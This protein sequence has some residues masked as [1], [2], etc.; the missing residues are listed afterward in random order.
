MRVTLDS[1]TDKLMALK[2]KIYIYIYKYLKTFKIIIFK[3]LNIII[4]TK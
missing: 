1:K 2:K 4:N 3:Y